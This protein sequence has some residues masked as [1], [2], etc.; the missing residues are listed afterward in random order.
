M[1]F[2]MQSRQLRRLGAVCLLASAACTAS[3]EDSSAE[4][5][6]NDTPPSPASPLI[7]TDRESYRV[8]RTA[9]AI[10][11]DIVT[12]FTNHTSDTVRLHP[13]GPQSQP[14]F[15]LEKWVNGAWTPA[16]NQACPAILMLDPP[17]VAPHAQRTDTARVRAMLAPN[18]M[19]RFEAEPIAG[20]YRVVYTQAY[21]SWLP[22]GGPGELLPLEQRV[23]NT[24][25]IEE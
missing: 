24:F 7:T 6:A 3:R 9:E 4:S 20:S 5:Q 2:A 23:S 18:A 22:D 13:C 15:M 11:V 19:P 14:A 8:R 17:R 21:R 25:R 1:L 12:T 16:Y 10:E